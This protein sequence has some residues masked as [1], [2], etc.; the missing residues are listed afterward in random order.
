MYAKHTL[1]IIYPQA[2][3]QASLI[4]AGNLCF[5]IHMVVVIFIRYILGVMH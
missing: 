5:R 1:L 2:Y 4:E 3:S